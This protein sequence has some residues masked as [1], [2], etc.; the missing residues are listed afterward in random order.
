MRVDLGLKLSLFLFGLM[1]LL[2][3][4]KSWGSNKNLKDFRRDSFDLL[5][6]S[7]GDSPQYFIMAYMGKESAKEWICVC[8]YIYIYIYTTDSLCSIRNINTS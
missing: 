8:V 4:S 3:G 7:T 2:I 5:Y 6:N 1:L